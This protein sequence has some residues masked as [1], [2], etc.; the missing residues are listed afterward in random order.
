M[1]KIPTII[2]ID[3]ASNKAGVALYYN[4]MIRSAL[5]T[6]YGNWTQRIT[7]QRQQLELFL[8]HYLPENE[9]INHLVVENVVGFRNSKLS[10]SVG[11]LCS[12]PCIQSELNLMAPSCWKKIVKKCGGGKIQKGFAA[13]RYVRPAYPQVSDDEADAILMLL[14]YLEKGFTDE[15]YTDY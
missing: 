6:G 11:A 2:A 12:L 3:P 8:N 7:Q 4:E 5:L 13:L 9:I 10:Y 15:Q 1:R 14:A